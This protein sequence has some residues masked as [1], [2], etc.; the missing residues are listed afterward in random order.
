MAAGNLRSVDISVGQG[1]IYVTLA[2]TQHVYIDGREAD[3]RRV[4]PKMVV[5]RKQGDLHMT[6]PAHVSLKIR[7]VSGTV[8]VKGRVRQLDVQTVSGAQ[9][10]Q[11]K[12]HEEA[13]VRAVSD[14]GDIKIRLSGDLSP[15]ID[16]SSIR[17]KVG[18]IESNPKS[19]SL[20]TLRS[21]GG[22]ILVS[23]STE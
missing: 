11:L 6:L 21:Q 4:G 15:R 3:A 2:K 20:L 16:A 8:Q 17:G 13:Q 12:L 18:G 14:W 23:K 9:D 1:D 5:K 19:A 10:L 7:T 22:D